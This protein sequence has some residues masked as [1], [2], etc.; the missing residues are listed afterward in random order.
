[1]IFAICAAAVLDLGMDP[2]SLEYLS[3][4]TSMY[5]LACIVFGNGPTVSIS[6]KS[7]GSAAGKSSSLH[8]WR[9]LGLFF[10]ADW[11]RAY[12]V[13]DTGS[14]MRPVEVETEHVVLAALT[15]VFSN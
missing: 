6:T 9:Q 4:V 1:M 8:Q 11:E 13:V 3:V 7:S 10:S 2:V 5:R 12:N 15:W 14:H